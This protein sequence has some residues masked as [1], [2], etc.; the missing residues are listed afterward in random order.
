[1]MRVGLLG[2]GHFAKAHVAALGQLGDGVG[3]TGYA[4]RDE[5]AAFAEAEEMGAVRM[6]VDELLTSCDVDAVLV[7]VPNHL[8]RALAE[9]AL[10][11]GKHVF[12]EKPLALNVA[13][14]DGVLATAADTERVLMVGHLTRYL[15]A[16]VT[17]GDILAEGRLGAP[18]A[19]YASRMHSGG[20]DRPWRMDAELGGGV[21]FD[22]L[23]HD[24]DLLNWYLGHPE[25]VVARGRRHASGGYAY[26][27]ATFNY[28]DHKIALAE[29]GFVFRPPA[30]LRA[31]LRIV[32]ERGHIE[33]NTH[34]KETPI[35]V[36]EEGREE[37]RV[38]VKTE[39]LL[40]DGLVAEWGEFIRAVD[41]KPDGRLRN[42]DARWVVACAA[43]VV[44]AA[45]TGDEVAVR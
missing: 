38:S 35:R 3:V 12:C 25:S 1:M 45:D 5:A 33:V 36:F 42:E 13:D 10:R 8:H 39:N 44:H 2:A 15:P 6:G 19:A 11:A 16:Y 28:A 41:G 4:R 26:V 7:C 37:E 27:A 20:S 23:V 21:V 29:G 18:V 14:A 43:A 9:Q 34:D 32:C 31:T 40:I 22:L 24:L 30:E 17:A